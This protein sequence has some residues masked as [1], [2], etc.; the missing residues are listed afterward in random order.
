MAAK[1]SI[2]A[3][4]TPEEILNPTPKPFSNNGTDYEIFPMP[5]G[6]LMKVTDALSSVVSI[7]DSV[8]HFQLPPEERPIFSSAL[9]IPIVPQILKVLLPNATVIIAASLRQPES[10]VSDNLR[11]HKRLEALRLI[12]EAEDIPLIIKN[13]EALTGIFGDQ[14]ALTNLTEPLSIQSSEEN[15]DSLKN[16]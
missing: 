14:T 2:V 9:M 15:I 16:I 4:K 3:E 11:I 13:F 1:K 12:I 5:D 10:W 7:I 8:A 6:A